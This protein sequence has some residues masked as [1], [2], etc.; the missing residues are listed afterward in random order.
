M[1]FI[2]LPRAPVHPARGLPTRVP[3]CPPRQP[4]ARWHAYRLL[5]FGFICVVFLFLNNLNGV[6]GG[7]RGIGIFLP[8]P[9]V[10][11]AYAADAYWHSARACH[12]RRDT[13]SCRMRDLPLSSC[14]SASIARRRRRAVGGG[15]AWRWHS[16]TAGRSARN[17]LPVYRTRAAFVPWAGW[18]MG[19]GRPSRRLP[20]RHWLLPARR[21]ALWLPFCCAPITA[22]G[23]GLAAGIAARALRLRRTDCRRCTR[24]YFAA[25]ALRLR[26][27]RFGGSVNVYR[28]GGTAF[29]YPAFIPLLRLPIPLLLHAF[30]AAS[31]RS[32]AIA[33][34]PST[35]VDV[36][37]FVR[38]A[39]VPFFACLRMAWKKFYLYR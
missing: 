21:R 31:L 15:W 14:T 30:Y 36:R 17:F 27:R 26:A 24:T 3:C 18:R 22:G 20:A 12:L 8:S 25:A 35:S 16:G 9:S 1:P 2:H 37:R 33:L 34:L 11:D 6:C 13:G 29:F 4:A 38:A 7:W 19:D 39:R 10:V 32:A 23:G 5:P 28:D